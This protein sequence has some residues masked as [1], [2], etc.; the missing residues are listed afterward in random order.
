MDIKNKAVLVL[1][2]W[3]LVGS[4]VVRRLAAEAPKRIIITSM[5]KSEAQ[6]AAATFRKE[7]PKIKFDAWWGNIFV[8]TKYKDTDRALL[9]ANDKTR[10]IILHDIIDDLSDDILHE[11]ALHNL[12]VTAKPD[13]VI[14]C[15]NTATAI[16]YQDIYSSARTILND[17]DANRALTRETI[18]RLLASLYIP[19]LIRHIQLLYQGLQDA[20]TGAYVKIGTSGTGGMGLNIPYTHSEERP[21]R[22]LLSKTSVAGAH[23]LLLFLM[24]R[25]PEAPTT[26]EIKPTATIAWK[27]IGYDKIKKRGNPI[28]LVDCKSP[29]N[30]SNTLKI[31]EEK[32]E[33]A[34]GKDLHAVFIDTGENGIF[35]RGEFET[36]T[37][38]GQ[39]EMVT[40]E[41]IAENTVRE[42]KGV[43]TGKDIVN[44]L[45]AAVMGPTYRA[46]ILRSTALKQLDALEKEHDSDSIA[47]E[48]LGP[49]RLTKLL[50][51]AYILG[52]VGNS[53]KEVLGS[54]EQEL[55]KAANE[56]IKKDEELRTNILSIGIPILLRD[57]K[58]LLRANA[59]KIPPFR[60]ENELRSSPRRIDDWAAQGWVDLRPKN[61]VLWQKRI[62]HIMDETKTQQAHTHTS[63]QNERTPHYW[64]DFNSMPIAKLASWIFA[65]EDKGERMKQ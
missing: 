18:E 20:G 22:V 21:S 2:G 29:V 38:L 49:P 52:R 31:K 17:L 34:L 58:S 50:Y 23:S 43:N 35:S 15:I 37:S 57:G 28:A 6:D 62:K 51:E 54:D 48:M 64:D 56:F 19:Q 41:E 27:R 60:G 59:I 32:L 33:H 36:V 25:S 53:M 61:I 14:D 42:I 3:G 63:S 40:P 5:L 65:I 30:V 11:S 47:F 12:L 24:G 26:K 1:G 39:M 8:R 45:D 10:G 7:Y 4:A 44:A 46:G 13:C 9:L 16:A 55:A